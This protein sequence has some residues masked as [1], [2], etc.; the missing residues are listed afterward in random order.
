MNELEKQVLEVMHNL[1]WLLEAHESHVELISMND[2]TVVIRCVGFCDECESDCIGVAFK[3]RLP[4][5][6]L[7][8]Q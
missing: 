3:E 8:R 6:I 4:D 1:N 7:I 2:N 5:I